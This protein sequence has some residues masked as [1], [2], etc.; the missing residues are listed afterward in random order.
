M[1]LTAA[2]DLAASFLEILDNLQ[3][4]VYFVDRE[5]RIIFWNKAAERISGYRR[6]EVVGRSCSDNLLIHVDMHGRSVCRVACPVAECLEDTLPRETNLFLQHKDGHRVRVAVQVAPIRASD[7]EV[8]GVM[9]CFQETP[10]LKTVS[11]RMALLEE[12]ALLDPVTR[13]PN[14]YHTESELRQRLEE[15]ERYGWN[16]GVMFIDVDFFKRINDAHG[17]DMGDRVLALVARTLSGCLRP[18]DIVGRWGGEE[19][20]AIVLQVDG[21]K[22]ET[23][24]N[25]ALALVE[26]SR[27]GQGEEALRVTI[28]IGATLARPEDTAETLLKRADLLLYQSKSSGR[29]RATIG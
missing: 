9:E 18:F 10:D 6:D 22:L 15:L 7:G 26:Q 27:V 17:H 24:A 14:R 23:V 29:N 4:G 25:R 21:G 5:R 20:L 8:I 28:S 16:F 3:E 13:L 1:D 12:M 2:S 19:F 11:E